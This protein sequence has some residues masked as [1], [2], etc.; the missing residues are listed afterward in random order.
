VNVIGSLE[1]EAEPRR[2]IIISGHHDSAPV[3]NLFHPLIQRY[4]VITMFAPYLFYL[5]EIVLCVS[6]LISGASTVP[7]WCLW[8]LLAGIPFVLLYFYAVNLRRGTPG[9]GDNMIASVIAAQLGKTAADLKTNGGTPLRHTRI[10]LASF[11]GEEAGL[12]GSAAYFKAYGDNFKS[13]PTYHL[14]I[15]SIYKLED[16]HVLESDINGVV[17]L[18]GQMAR[19]IKQIGAKHNVNITPFK[20]IFGAGA[21]DA[22]E[23]ARIGITSTTIFGL[24]TS[25]FRDGMVYHTSGDTIDKIEPEAVTA[26]LK[27]IWNYIRDMDTVRH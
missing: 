8:I 24:P 3:T 27:I 18:S 17:P 16:M 25:V 13:V 12:R 26:C 5:F 23:S 7:V 19:Q 14:N 2:Q 22:A 1:P 4:L 9:A 15:E 20:M 10:I 11:D 6:L 21:T